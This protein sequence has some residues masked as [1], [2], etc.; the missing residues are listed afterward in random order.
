MLIKIFFGETRVNQKAAKAV[1]P[2]EGE[3]ENPH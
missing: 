1:S 3:N 2:N